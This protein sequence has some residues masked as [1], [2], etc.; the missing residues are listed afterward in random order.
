MSTDI[1]SFRTTVF[2]RSK[3]NSLYQDNMGTRGKRRDHRPTAT[4]MDDV[5][6]PRPKRSIT[7]SNPP[8]KPITLTDI[9]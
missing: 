7:A 6:P 5:V 8:T 1:S 9:P 2:S 3:I 4:S